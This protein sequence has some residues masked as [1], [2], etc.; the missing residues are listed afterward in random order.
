ME[1]KIPLKKSCNTSA[2][3][4]NSILKSLAGFP[5][6]WQ[7]PG[8]CSKFC[9]KVLNT[10]SSEKTFPIPS[11]IGIR[12]EKCRELGE[13][14]R[15]F[16]TLLQSLD[17]IRKAATWK[18]FDASFQNKLIPKSN[19]IQTSNWCFPKM[20]FRPKISYFINCYTVW[21]ILFHAYM[22][23]KLF[24]HSRLQNIVMMIFPPS[25]YFKDQQGEGG[26]ILLRSIAK[27]YF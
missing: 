15:I 9:G 25:T 11:E 23:S 19:A 12:P 2:Q 22:I 5:K 14:S 20:N 7:L 3:N 21:K 17:R 10:I 4:A 16:P 24:E 26:G 1:R 27:T 6:V 8:I 13:K 18:T